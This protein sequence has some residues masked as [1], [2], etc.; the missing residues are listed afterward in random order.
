MAAYS[1]QE[2][3]DLLSQ[4]P[5]L[6]TH[7][8]YFTSIEGLS[9]DVTATLRVVESYASRLPEKEGRRLRALAQAAQVLK[10]RKMQLKARLRVITPTEDNE[11]K[12]VASFLDPRK[13]EL[14]D[15]FGKFFTI[16]EVYRK[17]TTDW[18]IPI[19]KTALERFRVKHIATIKELQD[20][21][22]KD[23]SNVRLGIKRS[24]L[25]Q[26]SYLYSD[27]LEIYNRTKSE[28][29]YKLLLTTLAEI[30]REVEGDKLVI[31][32][33]LQIQA[34]V[35]IN[36]H[37]FS[38]VMSGLVITDIVLARLAASQGIDPK[39]F[40]SKFHSSYYSKFTGLAPMADNPNEEHISY[41]SNI[42]YNFDRIADQNA[43][44]AAEEK[45]Q[46]TPV[47]I[48]KTPEQKA[49]ADLLK[50]LLKDRLNQNRVSMEQAHNAAP[51]PDAD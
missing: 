47:V 27:R 40:I 4:H 2:Q 21:Y 8:R 23:H 15:L 44:I 10:T 32:G 43:V 38:T 37:L 25:D 14:L 45:V 11:I 39:Y 16:G 36:S 22:K 7:S 34:E 9:V 13:N 5:L 1:Y 6:T 26:L 48:L 35:S 19:S 41:P 17:V 33:N 30:R 18:K 42:I 31:D 46:K 51:L 49:Q 20:A 24:R 12:A 28:K 3:Y 50:Q 29:D